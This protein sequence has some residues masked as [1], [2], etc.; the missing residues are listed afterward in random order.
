MIWAD[1]RC[2]ETRWEKIEGYKSM[3]EIEEFDFPI[4][5]ETEITE[6][7]IEEWL[8]G[9]EPINDR[10]YL[11]LYKYFREFPIYK[12]PSVMKIVRVDYIKKYRLF[13][14]ESVPAPIDH[15]PPMVFSVSRD[16]KEIHRFGRAEFEIE[17]LIFD[18]I[19]KSD[20][21]FFNKMMK[22]EKIKVEDPV[23]ALDICMLFVKIA[24]WVE[25]EVVK[26]KSQLERNF[27]IKFGEKKEEEFS[28]LRK[29]VHA[30]L[31][32]KKGNVYE[33]IFFTS[34]THYFI[35]EWHFEISTKGQIKLI[36]FNIID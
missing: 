13:W 22:K 24:F 14:I 33:L 30:P 5:I 3:I 36:G 26:D 1:V 27:E 12:Y 15:N 11:A 17:P 32:R 28:K 2:K 29:L 34:I 6:K 23:F 8:A 16:G 9:N 19:K 4:D 35:H 25:L 18:R 7:E 31:Y 21:K 20:I 10:E